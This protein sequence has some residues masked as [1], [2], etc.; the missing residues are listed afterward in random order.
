MD[1]R[2]GGRGAVAWLLCAEAV[3]YGPPSGSLAVPIS[4]RLGGLGASPRMQRGLGLSLCFDRVDACLLRDRG[5]ESPGRKCGLGAVVS[6]SSSA[7]HS[8]PCVA[9]GWACCPGA[10]SLQMRSR[11]AA[12][13]RSSRGTG[14]CTLP[15]PW[16]PELGESHPA[17][18]LLLRS[19]RPARP[20]LSASFPILKFEGRSLTT[21]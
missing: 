19:P 6:W 21:K 9:S 3:S 4:R 20:C 15:V 5:A 14:K 12:G 16:P 7:Q 2:A 8:D 11:R 10:P 1:G 18:T 17:A 13:G